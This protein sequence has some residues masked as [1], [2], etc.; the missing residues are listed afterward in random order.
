MTGRLHYVK[1]QNANSEMKVL[2]IGMPRGSVLGPLLFLIFINDLLNA[3]NISVTLF[4]DDIF[5]SLDSGDILQL[6]NEV[7]TEIKKYTAG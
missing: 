1:T 5:L 7:N 2:N 3:T 6:Q 4:A